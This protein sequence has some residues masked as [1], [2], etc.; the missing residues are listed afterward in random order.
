MAA[1]DTPLILHGRFGDRRVVVFAFDPEKS[2]LPHLA[3]FPLLMANSVDWLT[4]G[5][6]AVLHGGLGSK[7]NI[8]PRALADIPASSA[9]AVVPSTSE[10]WPW[11]LAA[12]GLVFALEWFV[13]IRRG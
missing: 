5:R 7:S 10:L 13:A 8:Q 9:A 1:E 11:F 12:A 3:A 6:Q 2:N 4:P